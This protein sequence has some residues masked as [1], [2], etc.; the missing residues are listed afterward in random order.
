VIDGGQPG[1]EHGFVSRRGGMAK[2]L[3]MSGQAS[4]ATPYSSLH[5]LVLV[6]HAY[7]DV[8][9][10]AVLNALRLASVKTAVYLASAPGIIA[11]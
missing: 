1:G 11:Y 10:H 4:E 9:R 7:P 5:H 2:V 3:E 8:E 6:P